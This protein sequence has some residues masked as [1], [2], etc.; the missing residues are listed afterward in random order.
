MVQATGSESLIRVSFVI[1]KVSKLIECAT[2]PSS[3]HYAT[4]YQFLSKFCARA[5]IKFVIFTLC[6][7]K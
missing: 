6:S 1:I 5:L 2:N 7:D 3:W 4:E